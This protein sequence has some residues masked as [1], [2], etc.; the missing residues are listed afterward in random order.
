MRSKVKNPWT[1]SSALKNKERMAGASLQYH[2]AVPSH[3][4][5]VSGGGPFN[6][7]LF[8]REK[9]VIMTNH[10][11]VSVF[12]NELV[13]NF[14]AINRIYLLKTKKE[15]NMKHRFCLPAPERSTRKRHAL[16]TSSAA[17]NQRIKKG[18]EVG[19]FVLQ[20]PRYEFAYLIKL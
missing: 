11:P 9:G 4:N 1:A 6:I 19:K 10:D 13:F 7:I 15:R 17:A 8:G 2:R 20:I 14:S 3:V 12:L 16:C 5:S 18:L